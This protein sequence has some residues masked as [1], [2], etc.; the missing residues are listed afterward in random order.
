MEG[1]HTHRCCECNYSGC[2]QH[3]LCASGIARDIC[4]GENNAQL[5][6]QSC[7]LR[8]CC[9]HAPLFP[10]WHFSKRGAGRNDRMHQC[11]SK[12][13][14]DQA[15]LCKRRRPRLEGHCGADNKHTQ[16]ESES[17]EHVSC[18]K[19]FS[20]RLRQDIAEQ[21]RHV[22]MRVVPCLRQ[23][24]HVIADN[25]HKSQ[26]TAGHPPDYSREDSDGLNS[27]HPKRQF[28]LVLSAAIVAECPQVHGDEK[29]IHN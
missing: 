28:R 15:I 8:R 6:A 24:K 22:P 16:E 10:V 7:S 21:L 25:T 26:S 1:A 29:R 9:K 14:E 5:G 17:T 20:E 13:H 4:Q 19:D 12:R 2:I 18:G 3:P 11:K 27:P 23:A